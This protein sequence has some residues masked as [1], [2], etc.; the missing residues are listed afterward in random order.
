MKRSLILAATLLAVIIGG[1]IWQNHVLNRICN[2]LDRQLVSMSEAIAADDFEQ[3]STQQ[4]VFQGH[5]ERIDNILAM[6]SAHDNIDDLSRQISKLSD[7]LCEDG[8]VEALATISDLRSMLQEVHQKFRVNL[9]N[10]L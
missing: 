9:V 8:K 2:D 3:A 10:V 6:I 4:L 5:W 7:Y 1:W